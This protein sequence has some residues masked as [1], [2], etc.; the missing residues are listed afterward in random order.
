MISLGIMYSTNSTAALMIDG[1]IEA[2]ASED[3]FVRKKSIHA[4]PK[5]SIDFCLRYTG[6]SPSEI[7]EVALP[8]LGISDFNKFIVDFDGSFSMKE[9][10]E[11]QHK[12]YKP[13]LIEGKNVNY[14]NVFRHKIIAERLEFTQKDPEH[15][16]IHYY[17]KEHLGIPRQKIQYYPHNLSHIYYGLYTQR[18]EK[19]PI[20]ILS[21]E[22]FGGDANASIYLY[23]NGQLR[24]IY[25][26]LD[27]VIGRLYRYIT[28]LLG[29]K[30][31]EHEYKVMGLAPYAN[32]NHIQEPLKIFQ[33]IMHVDG[34]ELKIKNKPSDMYF[35]FRDEFEGIRFDSIAGALQKYTENIMTEWTENA[36]EKTGIADVIWSGGVAMNIK[37]MMEISKIPALKSLCVGATPSDES[38]AMGVLFQSHCSSQKTPP[39]HLNNVY[40][41]NS[42]TRQETESFIS[43]INPGNSFKITRDPRISY[44]AQYLVNDNVIA[45][46]CGRMEFG[47]R[48]LGNRSILANPR[49]PNMIRKINE[50]IKN[51]DFWMPFA[52]VMLKERQNDYILNVKNIESPY[53]TIGFETTPLAKEHLPA[54]LHPYDFTVRPQILSREDN[55]SYYDLV[56]AFEHETGIGALLNTSFNMHGEP[57][58]C[59]QENAWDV[60]IRSGL[61]GL[62]LGHV[63]IEKKLDI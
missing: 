44:I 22:G 54:A 15:N 42:F 35:Y 36:I 3:R 57:I 20:L 7:D 55:P 18:V 47:A 63:F 40:L 21:M 19:D 46:F 26:T 10:I 51:R 25:K 28:L 16:P 24:L 50:K 6:V 43:Q 39:L 45:R 62:L 23:E 33:N 59:T 9:K 49:H 8:Y 2:C 48:A 61:D 56:K 11:E 17:L 41:G 4:Y 27:C 14:L 34:I 52:P 31:N 38:I 53:M 58:A 37:A 1:K 12:Y 5:Q 60:F 29:M 30:S 32:Q 13:I